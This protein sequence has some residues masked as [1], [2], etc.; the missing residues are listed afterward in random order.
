M[1]TGY[2][3]EMVRLRALL[4]LE[5]NEFVWS[6]VGSIVGSRAEPNRGDILLRDYALAHLADWPEPWGGWARGGRWATARVPAYLAAHQARDLASEL[7]LRTWATMLL[8]GPVMDANDGLHQ[9]RRAA[10]RAGRIPSRV[11]H[12][13]GPVMQE[14]ATAWA[15][16]CLQ[17]N[18]RLG[19]GALAVQEWGDRGD[20]DDGGSVILKMRWRRER[21]A[22]ASPGDPNLLEVAPVQTGMQWRLHFMGPHDYNWRWFERNS[23][24]REVTGGLGLYNLVAHRTTRMTLEEIVEGSDNLVPDHILIEQAR[25]VWDLME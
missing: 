13:G 6:A 5:P 24:E 1:T 22:Q 2:T 25:P 8:W 9:S 15:D 11:Q 14:L 4:A 21:M 23:I 10:W 17:I 7:D 16:A 19:H 18:Q 3:K 12:G 20:G